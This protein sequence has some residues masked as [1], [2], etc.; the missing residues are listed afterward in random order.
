MSLPRACHCHNHFHIF[1]MMLHVVSNVTQQLLLIYTIDRRVVRR[2]MSTRTCVCRGPP[3]PYVRGSTRLESA[4]DSRARLVIAV[5]ACAC[6]MLSGT[7][8]SM[9]TIEPRCPTPPPQAPPI[10]LQPTAKAASAASAGDEAAVDMF[11]D[12]DAKRAKQEHRL[13]DVE[14]MLK[15]PCRYMVKTNNVY[16][17]P[18]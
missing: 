2:P 14:F 17:R 16:E 11:Q 15:I 13:E 6:N 8:Q 18:I 4:A 12:R 5:V 10:H 7:I 1:S 3:T 9:F